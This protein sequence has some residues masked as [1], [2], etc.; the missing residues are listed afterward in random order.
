MGVDGTRRVTVCVPVQGVV[1]V[2]RH[3]DAFSG[4][5]GVVVD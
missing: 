4:M 2:A 1:S 3:V 5:A